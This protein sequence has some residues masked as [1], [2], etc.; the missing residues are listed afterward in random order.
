M[1]LGENPETSDGSISMALKEM[2]AVIHA[3][4]DGMQAVRACLS[5]GPDLVILDVGLPRMNGYQCARVLKHDPVTRATPIV[6]VG[7]S[8]NPLDRY[9]SKVCRAD[10]FLCTP[11]EKDLFQDTLQTIL[12]RRTIRRRPMPRVSLVSGLQDPDILSLA[13]NLLEQDLLLSSV[14]NEINRIDTWA[15]SPEDLVTSLLAIIHSLFVFSSGAALLLFEKHSE[16]YVFPGSQ[17]GNASLERTKVLMIE[18]LKAKH[19]IFVRPGDLHCVLLDTPPW[20]G[21]DPGKGEVFLHTRDRAPVRSVLAF[22]DM[23]VEDLNKEEQQILELALELAHGI[24]EKKI[25]S[26]IAQELSVIDATTQGHSM[27][28]FMEVLEREIASA[29]RNHYTITLFTI[30]ITNFDELTLD[31]GLEEQLGTIRTIQGAILRTMRKTDIIARWNQANFAFLL[32]HTTR[33][34]AAV[35]ASRV[36]A[37]ILEDLGRAYPSLGNLAIHMGVCEFDPQRHQNPEEF[38]TEAI[39]KRALKAQEEIPS[40]HA[41]VSTSGENE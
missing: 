11:V 40:G 39:P 8:A 6:H 31:L 32:T 24:L 41:R 19:D 14:L 35:P 2:D 34:N 1:V 25:F 4:A 23:N 37:N 33:E 7:P 22:E 38:L 13:T 5:K 15:T 36:R 3:C 17:P 12:P 21:L 30:L 26:R 10:S 28:F 18:H 20:E 9:W 27:T 16:L 29:R